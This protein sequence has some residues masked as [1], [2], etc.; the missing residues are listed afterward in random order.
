MPLRCSSCDYQQCLCAPAAA[1]PQRRRLQILPCSQQPVATT[2]KSTANWLSSSVSSIHSRTTNRAAKLV[3]HA[4][5][6]LQSRDAE[7]TVPAAPSETLL[8]TIATADSVDGACSEVSRARETGATAVELRLDFYTDFLAKECDEAL[9]KLIEGC[10]AAQLKS[11]FTCRASWEGC[12][13]LRHLSPE[14]GAL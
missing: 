11:L 6:V 4:A 12:A 7:S 10:R 14:K 1:T 5:S 8:C 13:F 3:T 2:R 9:T